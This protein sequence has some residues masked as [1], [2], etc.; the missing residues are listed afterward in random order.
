[1][2][3]IEVR[4]FGGPEVL[5]ARE[6]PDPV[7]G[8][9]Q[10]VVGLAAADVIY[11]DTLLRG[12]WGG[13]H[14]PINLPYVPGG[15][16]AG[17]VLTVGD[18]VDPAWVGRRV[19]ARG[20]GGYAARMA[21]DVDQIVPVPDEVGWADAAA[22]LHDGVTAIELLRHA[23]VAAGDTVL[24]AAAAGGA[25]SLLV[26]LASGS[27]ARVVAGARGERKLALA[28]ELGAD[29]AVDYSEDGWQHRVRA[30]TGGDG[31]SVAFDGAGG[32]LGGAAFDTVAPG[33]KFVTY[34][35]AGG[36]FTEIDPELAAAR[37]V[38]VTNALARQLERPAVRELL[39]EALTLTAAGRIRPAIGA[40]H[41]LDR[42]ADAHAALEAR[43]TLGKSL[44]LT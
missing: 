10:V 23:P 37:R 4:E 21:T 16:G 31:V 30:A 29:V 6:L 35:T 42:A 8:P 12:G 26:Q 17:T 38:Q 36:G 34:G 28:R 40:T 7:A 1:M 3:A 19:L 41:P 20:A 43:A 39:A 32:G 15:G 5:I 9:G 27:G 22:L 13:E 25:G 33:G 14:F 44:L 24:V 2:H 11:L 18:G